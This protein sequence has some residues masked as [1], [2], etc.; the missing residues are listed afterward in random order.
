M[1]YSSSR[2]AEMV[3]ERERVD[4]DPRKDLVTSQQVIYTDLVKHQTDMPISEFKA[5]CLGVVDDIATSGVSMTLTK[6]G[7]AVARVVPIESV[8]ASLKG[9]WSGEVRITGD[10]V[11]FDLSG[12]WDK[13]SL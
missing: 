1:S 8:T 10:L 13:P 12:D 2:V 9:T 5:K 11:N 6:R 3:R 7:H 4:A